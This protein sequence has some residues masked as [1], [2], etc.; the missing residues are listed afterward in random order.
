M[1]TTAFRSAVFSAI[2]DHMAANH[3]DIHM[4][5]ENGPEVDEASVHTGIAEVELRFYGASLTEVGPGSSNR[6]SG[7]IAVWVYVRQSAGLAVSDAICDGLES[8]LRRKRIGAGLTKAP[9]RTVPSPNKGWYRTG[10][11]VPFTLDVK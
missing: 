2:A 6:H 9:Q 7:A 1:S 11:T 4:A 3:A 8:L 10:I 5:W